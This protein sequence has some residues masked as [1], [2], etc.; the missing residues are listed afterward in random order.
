MTPGGHNMGAGGY[1]ICPKCGERTNHRQG[2]P[3][4][5][6]KCPKRGAK[7]LRE[8]SEHHKLL[9]KKRAEKVGPA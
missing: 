4:Q 9:L 8:G 1:C 3:C 5:Q 2:I 6:D 7:M